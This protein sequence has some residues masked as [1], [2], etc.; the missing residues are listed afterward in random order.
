VTSRPTVVI[1]D[2]HAPTR[3]GV[4]AVLEEA[5]FEVV[6]EAADAAGAVAAAQQARPDIC[7]LDVNMPGGGVHAARRIA[8]VVPTAAVVI[9]TVS[10]DDD[11]LFDALKAG[12]RGYLLKDIDPARLGP[13][14]RSVL[15]GEA[16]L[17]RSLTARVIEEF[18]HRERRH[19]LPVLRNRGVELTKSE[20]AV[21]ELLKDGATTAEMAERQGVSQVTIRSHV[22]AILKKLRV[23]SRREAVELL[24]QDDQS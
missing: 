21:L 20:W 4:R 24:A 3:E 2:D 11:N 14:L 1:A 17:P 10:A 16:A 18:R 13:T 5:G 9:L 8:D 7:L 15:D 22:S 6:G 19:R 23:S 12:A